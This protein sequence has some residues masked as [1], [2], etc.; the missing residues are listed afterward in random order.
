MKTITLILSVLALCVFS[1]NA[2]TKKDKQEVEKACRNYVEGWATGDTSRISASVSPDLVKR[3]IFTNKSGENYIF[4]MT[5]D[6]LKQAA[7]KNINGVQAKDLTPNKPFKL[8]VEICDIT[9]NYALVKAWNEKYGF[10]DYCQLA[11]YNGE[12]KVFNVMWGWL[13]KK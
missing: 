7:L 4:S 6:E 9:N 10:F 5:L 3:S 13:P 11:K 2:Q 8:K 1:L 12:W